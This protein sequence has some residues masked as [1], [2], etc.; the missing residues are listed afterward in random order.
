MRIV[1]WSL[2]V[3][4]SVA[5]RAGAVDKGLPP[6]SV[7][8]VVITSPRSGA[9]GFHTASSPLTLTYTTDARFGPFVVT[10]QGGDE[11]YGASV[12]ADGTGVVDVGFRREGRFSVYVTVTSVRGG[13]PVAAGS[14]RV[15]VVF[16]R[17]GPVV[18]D[19]GAAQGEGKLYLW[20]SVRDEHS[21]ARAIEV[22]VDVGG[23][24]VL[25]RPD[26]DG[27]WAV[28]TALPPTG[29]R[30][31]VITVVGRERLD[32]GTV[33]TGAAVTVPWETVE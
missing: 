11:S 30:V 9:T 29:E 4:A 19:V 21:L 27:R 22:V 17:T 3:V 31:D 16:D 2:L 13:R 20:G 23:A 8:Y 33:Q 25:A 5:V 28:T 6:P 7:S 15:A 14:G 24:T 26:D 32:D 18:D 12:P 10:S 1:L